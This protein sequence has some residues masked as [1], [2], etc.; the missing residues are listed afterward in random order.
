MKQVDAD[1]YDPNMHY[2]GIGYKFKF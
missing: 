2:I 1:E